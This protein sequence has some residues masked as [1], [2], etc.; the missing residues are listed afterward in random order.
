MTVDRRLMY[1]EHLK[2][3]STLLSQKPF[4]FE[5]FG[6]VKTLEWYPIGLNL[7]IG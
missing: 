3:G 5:G 2:T 6:K 1:F 7:S 4:Y